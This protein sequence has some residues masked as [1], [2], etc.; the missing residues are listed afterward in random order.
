MF[1][2]NCGGCHQFTL[3]HSS[4]V[5]LKSLPSAWLVLKLWKDCVSCY[6]CNVFLPPLSLTHNAV[7]SIVPLT[8]IFNNQ[9]CS[10]HTQRA[11]WMRPTLQPDLVSGVLESAATPQRNWKKRWDRK[12]AVLLVRPLV[13]LTLSRGVDQGSVV[14]SPAWCL[15]MVLWRSPAVCVGQTCYNTSMQSFCLIK[16]CLNQ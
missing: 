15:A 9:V 10:K 5:T 2:G 13:S 11:S 4:S 3:H 8:T 1:W 7:F 16:W 6:F 12:R 14:A